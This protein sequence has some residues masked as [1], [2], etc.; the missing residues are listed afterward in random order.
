MRA[1]SQGARR[2]GW[3]SQ[4]LFPFESHFVEIDGH[5]VHYVDEGAGPTLL[6]LHG[7]PTWSFVYRDVIGDLRDEFRCVALDYPG[8]GLS[9]A[10]PGYRFAPDEHAAVVRAVIE[11]LDLSGVTLVMQ[12]WGGP[13]GL[14]AA[15]PI[16]QRF[17]GLVV[18]NTWAWPVNGDL[19]FEFFSRAMG[20]LLGR[21]LIRRLNL[22]VNAL[23]PAGHR[24]RRLSAAEMAH[25]R[26]ALSTRHRRHASAVF[27][28]AITSSRTF[29]AQVERDLDT[30]ARLPALILWADADIAFRERE[31][32]RWE[33]TLPHSTTT[34]LHGAGHYLQSDAPADF[35]EAIRHWAKN[36]ESPSDTPP[37][38]RD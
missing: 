29:L 33:A 6:L 12:D 16:P 22:F 30:L 7:N 15:A 38:P 8:F 36:I 21:E 1:G 14:A 31:R 5:L 28:H 24:R 27:P 9:T 4:E 18:A 20:G 10:A 11:H 23:L 26:A 3:V 37:L 2:P 34:I 17:D 19:H 13:I 25:Y 35:A 32:H